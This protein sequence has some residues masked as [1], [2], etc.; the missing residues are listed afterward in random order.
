MVLIVSESIITHILTR[1]DFYFKDCP[2]EFC[3]TKVVTKHFLS[4]GLEK[5][6]AELIADSTTKLYTSQFAVLLAIFSM[7]KFM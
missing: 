2:Y 1:D 5:L 4:Q 3:V 6:K 7:L